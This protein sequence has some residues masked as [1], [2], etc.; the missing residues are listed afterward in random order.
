LL[1]SQAF[2]KRFAGR[3]FRS[4]ALIITSVWFAFSTSS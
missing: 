2:V 4:T 1:S 3:D